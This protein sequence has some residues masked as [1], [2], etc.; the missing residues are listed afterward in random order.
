MSTRCACPLTIPLAC[1]LVWPADRT[2]DDGRDRVVRLAPH[3]LAGSLY[4]A[5]R[6]ATQLHLAVY[7]PSPGRQTAG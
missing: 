5:P 6:V 7:P 1:S 3:T 2:I 4:A